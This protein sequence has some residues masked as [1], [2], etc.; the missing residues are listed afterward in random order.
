MKIIGNKSIFAI[1]YEF[2][3]DTHETELSMI[4]NGDNILSYKMGTDIFTTRWNLDDLAMWLRQFIDNLEEDP[5][6]VNVS[7]EYAAEKDV[8]AREFDSD[9]ETVFDAYYDK[10]DAWNERHR[11]HPASSGAILADVYFQL[12]GDNVEISWNNEDAEEDAEFTYE[13]GGCKVPASEFKN[14]INS[15]LKE[16][17]IHWF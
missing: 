4:I 2:F 8:S 17:A 10:L 5:Y 15:F 7:G 6:P 14:V 9:D 16:Y 13:T 1:G 3:D 11:W 12:V